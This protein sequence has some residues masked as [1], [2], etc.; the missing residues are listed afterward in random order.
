L[1]KRRKN[2]A[3][4]RKTPQGKRPL[5]T[6]LVVAVLIL[7]AFFILEKVKRRGVPPPAVERPVVTERHKMPERKERPAAVEP[8]EQQ[9]YTTAIPLPPKRPRKR[10]IGPGSVAIIIDDMGSSVR[11]ADELMAINLPL[12]FSLIPGLPRV[13]A[14]AETAHARG[15]QLMIHIPME[16][17][18]YPRQRMEGYGLLLSQSD[19]EIRKRM[20]GFLRE[21][22]FAKGAN[23]HMGSRFT[24][25]REKMATVLGILKEKGLFFI[26]S[27][28]S[29]R[30]VGNTLA[31]EMGM[32]NAARNVFLDN[33]QDVEAI[34]EQLEQLA[35]MARRRGAAIGICHPHRATIQ[36]L[37]TAM[38]ELQKSGI[39]FVYAAD[40]VR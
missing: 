37:A 5:V 2:I 17:K 31:R 24:E 29:P 18:G 13:K 11:E 33:V 23:N 9:P 14:V 39:T 8:V 30:S 27:K 34:R 22:P 15:Y 35:A 38:P 28:T 21:V 16:P 12:T 7:S 20:D 26:D 36:A 6:L 10:A 40:L 4:N 32:E 19:G 25:E 3:K 1:A